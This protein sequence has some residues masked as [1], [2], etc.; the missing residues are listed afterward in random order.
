MNE[1][2]VEWC[3][4]NIDMIVGWLKE[5]ANKRKLP[6]INTVA[7]YFVKKAINLSKKESI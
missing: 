7:K 6:F 1:K 5:E 4:Q 2:G 3:E